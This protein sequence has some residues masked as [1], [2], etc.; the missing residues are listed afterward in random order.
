MFRR[1]SLRNGLVLLNAETLPVPHLGCGGMAPSRDDERLARM[2][3][4]KRTGDLVE[5]EFDK[6]P[7]SGVLIKAGHYAVL[8]QRHDGIH[9]VVPRAHYNWSCQGSRS[10][11]CPGAK[12][13]RVLKL[14]E[15]GIYR[16]VLTLDTEVV[17]LE[18]AGP[19]GPTPP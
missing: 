3:D 8:A 14:P 16:G 17:V 15:M 10:D 2:L 4:T 7:H 9:L 18:V 12:W 19:P 6:R 13:P 1:E 5:Y 11:P